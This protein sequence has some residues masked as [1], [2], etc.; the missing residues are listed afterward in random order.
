MIFVL[1]GALEPFIT[2]AWKH[3][4]LCLTKSYRNFLNK[5]LQLNW[6]LNQE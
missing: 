6:Y 3:W 1:T 2:A 5:L 4:K